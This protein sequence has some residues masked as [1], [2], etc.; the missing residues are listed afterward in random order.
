[1]TTASETKLP[2]RP[3][4]RGTMEDI[5]E[6]S[7]PIPAGEQVELELFEIK[8]PGEGAKE[9][10]PDHALFRVVDNPNPEFNGKLISLPLFDNN[11]VKL[12]RASGEVF[13]WDEQGYFPA[14]IGL[15]LIGNVTIEKFTPKGTSEV[16]E[17]N[18]IK[19]SG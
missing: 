7:K 12:I 5:I 13:G 18:G 14:C 17:K 15:R 9:T 4:I 11:L 10:A 19:F 8:G 1:M 16:V 3:S 2:E 6:Q